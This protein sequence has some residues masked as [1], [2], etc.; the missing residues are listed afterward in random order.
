MNPN[1]NRM[2]KIFEH[3]AQRLGWSAAD[4]AEY[5]ADIKAAIN[6]PDPDR[7][8]WWADRLEDL[9]NLANLEKQCRAMESRIHAAA[10][11]EM[12]AA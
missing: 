6:K 7:L 3:A 10:A 12:A 11:A 8:Q 1:I 5:N 9:S 2:R 4:V